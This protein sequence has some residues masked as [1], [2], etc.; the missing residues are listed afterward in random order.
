MSIP[1]VITDELQNISVCVVVLLSYAQLV[2]L[3]LVFFFYLPPSFLLK[4]DPLSVSNFW[5]NKVDL[6]LDRILK[7]QWTQCENDVL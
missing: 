1:L 6:L 4:L 5:I 2:G 3:F 7:S